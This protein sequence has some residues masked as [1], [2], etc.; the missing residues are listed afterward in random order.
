[1]AIEVQSS[2]MSETIYKSILGTADIIRL[3]RIHDVEMSEF[4]SFAV[5]SLASKGCIVKIVVKWH[6][7]KFEV[8]L[9]TYEDIT[10]GLTEIKKLLKSSVLNCLK[11]SVVLT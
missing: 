2:L 10:A 7:F 4:I 1:M 3:A 11:L 8:N 5:P 6:G 9:T